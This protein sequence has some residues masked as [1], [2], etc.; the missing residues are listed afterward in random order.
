M[1]NL[2]EFID[3]IGETSNTCFSELVSDRYEQVTTLYHAI[4]NL[5]ENT[6]EDIGESYNDEE[7]FC[8]PLI[9]NKNANID[10]VWVQLEDS[11]GLTCKIDSGRN[12]IIC[13]I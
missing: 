2:I 10:D 7:Y 6:V 3:K 5:P 13:K 11:S 12:Y 4:Q 9:I 1:M 8:I